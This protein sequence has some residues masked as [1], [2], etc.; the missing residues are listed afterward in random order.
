MKKLDIG[1]ANRY[2]PLT[3]ERLQR[4]EKKLKARLPDDYRTFLLRY[5]GGR[6]ALSR[7]TFETHGEKQESVLEWFFAVHDLPYE[8]PDDWD[9]DGGEL[10]PYFGQQLEAVWAD[11]RR[12]KPKAGVLPIARDPGGN[13]I[14]IG[15]A[16]KRA[17]AVWW[18]DHETESFVRLAGSFAEFLTGLT[19]LP[20]GDWAPWLVM[21]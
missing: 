4:L 10:P 15:Y 5:N 18:Y 3:E 6:P 12:E 1:D 21:K 11:F 19:K 13:L 8:E 20:L 16:A 7:F 9:M 14:G 2:G 17:G